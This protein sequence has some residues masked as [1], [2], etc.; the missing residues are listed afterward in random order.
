M[1]DIVDRNQQLVEFLEAKGYSTFPV[2]GYKLINSYSGMEDEIN[3]LYKGVGLRNI[4]HLGIIELKGKDVLDFLHRISTNSIKDLP[5]EGVTK[6][7]FT[8]EKGK[9][10]GLATLL[11]FEN[12]QLLI[13]ARESKD[14]VMSWTKKYIIADD[15][16]V[17]DANTKYNLVELCGPQSGSFAT[18][19]CG[20]IVNEIK[21]NTFKIINTDNLLFF[22]IRLE[23]ERGFAKYWMLGDFENTKRLIGFAMDFKGVFNFNLVGEDAYNTYRIEQGIPASPDEI[24]DNFNPHEVGIINYVDFKKGCYIGQE[25][26]ARLDTY[27]KVQ[28]RLAGIKFLDDVNFPDK[29]IIYDN[30]GTEAGNVTSVTYSLKLKSHIGLA[31]IRKKYLQEG[32]IL[33]AKNQQGESKRIKIESLPFVR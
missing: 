20:N 16:I 3:S 26:I 27:D 14:K 6:T 8:S 5:K 10:L 17:N 15:V 7:V 9:I 23:N 1:F 19:I 4:S 30:E 32:N 31:L 22:L 2:D 18:L 21:P 33:Q 12:Y 29:Y 11:N 13:C 25:V 28:K 24:N